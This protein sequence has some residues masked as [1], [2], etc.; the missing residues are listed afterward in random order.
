MTGR[1]KRAIGEGTQKEH[2]DY[3]AA[4]EQE[5]ADQMCKSHGHEWEHFYGGKS[6]TRCDIDG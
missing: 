4:L 3:L 6:C 1:I 2:R 5:R